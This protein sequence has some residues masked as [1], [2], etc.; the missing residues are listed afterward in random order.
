MS[1]LSLKVA[2]QPPIMLPQKVEHGRRVLFACRDE[3]WPGSA[4]LR[5]QGFADQLRDDLF[6]LQVCTASRTAWRFQRSNDGLDSLRILDLVE[7]SH[8]E[9][10]DRCATILSPALPA[11][12]I[13]SRTGDFVECTV[14]AAA[15]LGAELIVM[16][17]QPRSCGNA[18]LQVV[19]AARLP[20]L[21][22]RPGRSQNIVVAATNLQDRRYP[23][24]RHARS[25]GTLLQ[26]DL[27]LVH[28]VERPPILPTPE[29]AMLWMQVVPSADTAAQ[30]QRLAAVAQT[31]PRCVGSVVK[32][33][34]NTAQ[35]IL[36]TSRMCD[37][38]LIVMGVARS[39]SRWERLLRRSVAANVA[40][41]AYRSVLLFPIAPPS[42]E[43]LTPAFG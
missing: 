6:V 17:P 12:R 29:V 21:I 10:V 20:V 39:Y 25:I 26:A 23:V 5:A 33:E 38:D 27:L 16:P 19:Q 4:L 3:D 13:A 31:M 24:L 36:E 2:S 41:G 15:E 1:T 7:R 32:S 14:Q 11:E 37:A 35:A 18:A 40:D 8:A 34:P 22:A 30:T 28:N 9:I 42:S 43:S